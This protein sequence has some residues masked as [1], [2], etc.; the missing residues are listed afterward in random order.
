MIVK[1]LIESLKLSGKAKDELDRV[2]ALPEVEAI[3]GREEAAMVAKRATLVERLENT[4]G[5]FSKR[6]QE[7]T[8]ALSAAMNTHDKAEQ[9]LR[10]AKDQLNHARANARATGFAEESQIGEIKAKLFAGRDPRLVDYLTAIT[11]I[12]GSVRVAL[13][14]WPEVSPRD[15][16]GH[17]ETVVRSNVSEMNSALDL[18][19]EV[20]SDIDRMSYEALTREQVSKRLTHWTD[21]LQPVL[22]PF[23]LIAP[24]LD[25]AGE[26]TANRRLT[27]AEVV[28]V[29]RK[30]GD[31]A[32]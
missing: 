22:K 24:S 4:P 3:L 1:N 18:I 19:R 13:T 23:S 32:A 17:K 30:P 20:R 26:V 6:K 25:E 12:E 15:M 29:I 10:D 31:I 16:W 7:T 14:V 5:Q 8:R 11:N 27:V 21:A 2:L 9:A 28:G